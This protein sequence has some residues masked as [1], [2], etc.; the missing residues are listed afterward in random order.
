MKNQKGLS[1]KRRVYSAVSLGFVWFCMAIAVGLIA[2]LIG[3]ILYRGLGHITWELLSTSRS[4]LRGTIGIWPNILFTLY[5][6][7]TTLILVLPVGIGAAIYLNEY[8]TNRR[9]VRMIEFATET[10]AGIPSIV[11]GMVGLLV[12]VNA[13]GLQ[14]SI[15]VGALTLA[16]MTL[17]IV[18][19]TTQEALKTVPHSYREGAFA[20][21]A[22]KWYMIRTI[23]LPSSL[24]G[25]VT[26][27]IL[28][29]G[30]MV[31]E[32]AALLLTAGMAF[33]LVTNYFEALGTRGAT[34]TVALFLYAT[35]HGE[36]DV[37][38]AIASI[39]VIIV[40]LLNFGVKLV[41]RKLKK[42]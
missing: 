5:I 10:L 32:S 12:F 31:G 21:G 17:P 42:I 37:S 38:F 9:L 11:Y 27:A 34:L 16:I 3:F 7:F 1:L 18:V 39:L 35:E 19:R 13:L 26:G 28:S 24:D 4:A 23:I 36:F 29:V 6:I 33:T 30:R 22:T 2:I 8:A 40:L 15:L 14:P 41:K 25:I 20:L